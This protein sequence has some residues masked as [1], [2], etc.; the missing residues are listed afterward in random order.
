MKQLRNGACSVG[1]RVAGGHQQAREEA[2]DVQAA[3]AGGVNKL[4]SVPPVWALRARTS[5]SEQ[6]NMRAGVDGGFE[7]I[8]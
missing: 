8:D 1:K 7:E 2:A 3:D 4:I 6:L 5:K